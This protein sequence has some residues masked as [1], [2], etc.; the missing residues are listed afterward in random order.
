ML[1]P[2]QQTI[3]RMRV[4]ACCWEAARIALCADQG[5]HVPA[6]K[7]STESIT[8]LR[9]QQRFAPHP[10]SWSSQQRYAAT[11]S[12]LG[13]RPPRPLTPGI[14]RRPSPHASTIRVR[15]PASEPRFSSSA[16][17]LL[18]LLVRQRMADMRDAASTS[19]AA[20]RTA[21]GAR[22]SSR[23]R[24]Q[25]RVTLLAALGLAALAL[26]P[27]SCLGAEE[28]TPHAARE[29]GAA[30]EEQQ[31][32]HNHRHNK[33]SPPLPK[34][35]QRPPP[36]PPGVDTLPKWRRRP[37]PSPP[38]Q[39]LAD[40]ALNG[41][42]GEEHQQQQQDQQWQQEAPAAPSPPPSLPGPPPTDST[43]R[44]AKA[45]RPLPKWK[46]R[47]PPNPPGVDNLPKWRRRPPPG[48][49]NPPGTPEQHSPDA[50]KPNVHPRSAA[51]QTLSETLDCRRRRP[52]A[53]VEAAEAAPRVA[54]PA[55]A[56]PAAAATAP[57]TA[58]AAPGGARHG[59]VD[60]SGCVA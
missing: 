30:Q 9:Q 16:T 4:C 19:R 35:K 22:G 13:G 53:Q 25:T 17:P 55:P 29:L 51:P 24:Q 23:R 42:P 40:A 5:R 8:R 58:A 50:P 18:V 6:P 41:L 57:A 37:P 32:H 43:P 21:S 10:K 20:R 14:W 59:R 39:L 49:P 52:D 36:N 26:A 38:G 12:F 15:P 47:P 11:P 45:P 33:P 27:T 54:A 3:G 44:K 7:Q 46:Q 1:Q 31:E 60:P 28:A 56:V 2:Q 34:W 48:P